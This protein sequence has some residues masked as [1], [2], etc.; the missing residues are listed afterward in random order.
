M[1]VT[2]SYVEINKEGVPIESDIEVMKNNVEEMF[3]AVDL[4]LMHGPSNQEP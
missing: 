3:K 1:N 4:T 2:K